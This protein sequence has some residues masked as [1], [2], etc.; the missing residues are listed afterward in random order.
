MVSGKDEAAKSRGGFQC[1]VKDGL[2]EDQSAHLRLCETLGRIV[3]AREDAAGGQHAG[4][5]RQ[6]AVE[7]RLAPALTDDLHPHAAFQE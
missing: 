6:Y 4:L 1:T 7:H 2:G 5:A 3:V